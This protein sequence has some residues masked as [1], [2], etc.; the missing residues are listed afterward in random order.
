MEVVRPQ[1]RFVREPLTREMFVCV[2]THGASAKPAFYGKRA[3]RQS[4]KQD[5]CPH[6]GCGGRELVSFDGSSQCGEAVPNDVERQ[7][8]E[9]AER[10][11]ELMREFSH[12]L[13]RARLNK[14]SFAVGACVPQAEDEDALVLL[15]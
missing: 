9:L 2:G 12:R 11:W 7:P 10:A 13:L 4:V 14:P 3:A 5:L 1:L 15:T 8:V 6:P